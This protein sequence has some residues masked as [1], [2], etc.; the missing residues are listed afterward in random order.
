MVTDRHVLSIVFSG[1]HSAP[2][3]LQDGIA[4]W[5]CGDLS[6]AYL[7]SQVATGARSPVEPGTSKCFVPCHVTFAPINMARCLSVGYF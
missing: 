2:G 7:T 6:L 1:H 5:D 4:R 3:D